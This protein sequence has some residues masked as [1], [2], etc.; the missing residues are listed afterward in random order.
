[1]NIELLFLCQWSVSVY[2]RTMKNRFTYLKLKNNHEIAN[3]VV[4]PAMASETAD[5]RGYV[6]DKTISH[7]A[8]LSR[9]GAGLII[10]EYSFVHNS[11]RS[12]PFQLA[13]DHDDQI[14]DLSII[15][16]VIHRS[17]ALAGIQLTH[18]GGKTEKVFTG[19]IIMA[20][21]SVITP[22]KDKELEVPRS[23]NKFDIQLWK[24]SFLRS[25][26][27]A[28][29]SG[30]D[31]IELHAAH[32][33]GLNQWL[34]PLTNKRED[35]YGGSLEN[36]MRLLLE[37][38]TSIR[39]KHPELLLSV[40]IPGQDF[41]EGGLTQQD[42]IVIAEKLEKS[43]VD[44][45]NVSSGIGG[46]RR[47]RERSGEGYLVKEA[48]LIQSHILIPVIGVGGIESGNFIDELIS[49]NQ[50]SLAAVGRAILKDPF[51]WGETNLKEGSYV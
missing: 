6:T 50:I 14:Q 2:I 11:G 45:I 23:M 39:L 18:A 41:L 32:G 34:S 3:R 4:I 44:I 37:I 25:A 16:Q 47:P 15:A 36:R 19:G 12:E 35:E 48:S 7:Y 26:D 33:Y 5:S 10:A 8:N 24:D 9:S 29:A 22:V 49:N 46:W 51:K 21:S 40:R 1:M 28:V 13:I 27:R 42:G 31:L 30:F 43:G 20:A 17:G 38:I